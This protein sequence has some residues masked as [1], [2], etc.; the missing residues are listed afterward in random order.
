M[1]KKERVIFHIDV[2]SAYL[3]FEAVYRLQH[4]ASVDL[5]EIPSAVAGSQETR[6]GIILAKS[7]PAKKYGVKTGEAIWEAKLKCPQLVLVP[8]NYPLYIK[9][10]N[11]M[12]ELLGEYTDRVQVF[13]IDKCFLDM[14][15]MT[16]R[17]GGPLKAAHMIKDR[18]K[19]ELGFTVGI[20]ISTN[21]L[22]AKMASDLKKPDAVCTLY[23]HEIP[24]KM[25][26][27]PIEDLYMVG[28]ATAPKLRKMGIETIED[29]ANYDVQILQTKL[30]SFGQLLWNY[31]NGIE[32]SDVA[33]GSGRNIIKGIGNSTTTPFDVEDRETTYQVLLSL[34]YFLKKKRNK[35]KK[36]A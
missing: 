22:L 29:L 8:P 2:N 16:D 17:L 20:G 36:G 23:P 25:W 35:N 18:I 32:N 15:H 34:L 30:K 5:R 7:I 21:K 13:S 27:L 24:E 9:C 6:H 12:V 31:A 28:R 33:T 14:T 3:S 4:G 1:A 11:A 10:H 19:N 26:P